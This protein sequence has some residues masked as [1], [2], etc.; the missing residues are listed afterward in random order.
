MVSSRPAQLR[1]DTRPPAGGLPPHD[2]AAEE[3]VIAALLLDEEA[4]PRVVAILRPEDFFREQNQWCYEACVALADRGETI[5]HPTVSHELERAGRLDAAGGEPYLFEITGK[6]FTAEGVEAH[7][8]IVAR[9]VQKP[10]RPLPGEP[11][12]HQRVESLRRAGDPGVAARF[13]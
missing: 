11:R 7:A 6:H 5:T 10:A 9:D 2:I 12:D 8:R 1:P 3:A 13:Q 4:Y